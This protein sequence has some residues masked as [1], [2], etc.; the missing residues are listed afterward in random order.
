[1]INEIQTNHAHTLIY[2][3]TS[4]TIFRR[5]VGNS[6]DQNLSVVR[7]YFHLRIFL[8]TRI[9]SPFLFKRIKFSLHTA[10]LR[11]KKTTKKKKKKKTTTK[12]Q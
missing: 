1:M 6:E 12:K 9:D 3:L 4:A 10:S 5:K 8:Y 11:K 7:Y 2:F